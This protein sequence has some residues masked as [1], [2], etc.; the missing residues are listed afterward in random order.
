M[1]KKHTAARIDT[2]TL[3][4][5]A[6]YASAGCLHAPP[7]FCGVSADVL[8]DMCEE[9]RESRTASVSTNASDTGE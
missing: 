1:T 5:L 8:R 7:N 4:S 6:N 9:I 2:A 3:D